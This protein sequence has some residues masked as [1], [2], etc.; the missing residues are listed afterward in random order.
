MIDKFSV[1]KQKAILKFESALSKNEVDKDI[2]PF[3]EK[4][5]K[6]E[7]YYTTSSCAGRI[8]LLHDLGSKKF[9]YFVGRWHRKVK[10]E[11]ILEHIHRFCE[12]EESSKGILWFKQEP[13]ILHIVSKDL[14]GAEKILKIAITY[15]LKHSGIISLSKQR[16]VVEINGNERMSVPIVHKKLL[17]ENLPEYLFSI[18]E[19]ANENF[20]KN[21]KRRNRFL[22]EILKI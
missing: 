15:G 22:E 12:K 8:I 21:E 4:F 1:Q 6:K 19:I 20:E 10:Y 3:L 7:N 2:I 16:Y 5:N 14:E 11:E 9:S 13:L 17:I 18:V